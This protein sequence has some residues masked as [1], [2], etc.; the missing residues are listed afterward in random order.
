MREHAQ[1]V[2]SLRLR[3]SYGQSSYLTSRP[4][5]GRR[6]RHGHHVSDVPGWPGAPSRKA[7][8]LQ[9]PRGVWPACA[10]QNREPVLAPARVS[11]GVPLGNARARIIERFVCE[12]TGVVAVHNLWRVVSPVSRGVQVLNGVVAVA[13]C[14]SADV[15][16]VQSGFRVRSLDLPGSVLCES[17]LEGSSCP[18][19]SHQRASQRDPD[20][21]ASS[22]EE[23]AALHPTF[24]D[25]CVWV[26]GALGNARHFHTRV[27]RPHSVRTACFIDKVTKAVQACRWPTSNAVLAVACDGGVRCETS[28]HPSVMEARLRPIRRLGWTRKSGCAQVRHTHRGAPREGSQVCMYTCG[29]ATSATRLRVRHTSAARPSRLVTH[30]C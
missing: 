27:V 5:A 11:C 24:T 7:E 16:V 4:D 14:S 2:F 17:E 6:V 29:K 3:N 22:Q 18:C 10:I 13:T 1:T 9:A 20:L 25:L 12:H 8:A 30:G 15:H 26:K 28:R 19:A 21:A 23:P